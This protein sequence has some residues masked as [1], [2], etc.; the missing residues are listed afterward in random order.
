MADNSAERS[1]NRVGIYARVSTLAG[2]DPEMQLRELRDY[3]ERRGWG[4][5]DEYVDQG[6]SGSRESRP[7]L[8][9][10][11]NDARLRKFDAVLVWKLDRFGRS[12]K[13]LVNALAGC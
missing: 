1:V 3:V 11:M 7:A 8:N 10:L 6:V 5:A 4:I 12:L 9:R 13:H 2:Q